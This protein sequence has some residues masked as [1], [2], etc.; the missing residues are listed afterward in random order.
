MAER[1]CR[2][3]TRTSQRSRAVVG[4]RTSI[5]PVEDGA[6]RPNVALGAVGTAAVDGELPAERVERVGAKRERAT[7]EHQRI[8][9]VLDLERHAGAGALRDEEPDIPGGGVRDEDGA[10]ERRDDL[11]CDPGEP[12]G[13]G[14]LDGPDSM[15]VSGSP[16]ALARIH[17]RAH[18][19][20]ALARDP[21][22]DTHLDDPVVGDVEAGHFEIDEGQ[23][24]LGDRQIP[25]RSRWRWTHARYP[26]AVRERPAS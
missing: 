3:P 10:A 18:G 1:A 16:D 5:A 26:R 23:R 20:D 6:H 11:P 7:C 22:L 25:R 19:A 14:D 4:A 17:E 21:A 8:Q 2:C 12:R 9:P 13:A 15:D 24:R